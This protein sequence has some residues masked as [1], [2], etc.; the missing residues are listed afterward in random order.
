MK[1]LNRRL[2]T[3]LGALLLSLSSAATYAGPLSLWAADGW[4]LMSD[5]AQDGI[6]GPGGGGQQFD[7]EGLYFKQSG[8]LLSIGLQSGFNLITGYESH[9]AS[10]GDY[11]AGDLA[12]SFDGS[13]GPTGFE[14]GLDFGL[15]T[16]DYQ[17]DLVDMGSTTGIDPAGFYS[18]SSWNNDVYSGH[19]SSNPFAIDGG[20]LL[21]SFSSNAS[22]SGVVGG[23]TSYYRT[24]TFDIGSLGL[25][26]IT[27]LDAHWT[28]SC[29]NDVIN[30]S[31]TLTSVPE[32]S[33]L[34]LMLGGLMGMGWIG[35]RK[36][37]ATA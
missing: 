7:A 4:T 31:G 12:L 26:G 19:T 14:Y 34:A 20:A 27:D 17:L 37:R 30:G 6:I 21:S 11:Y 25:S 35:R 33:M 24:V 23:E 3:G 10:P 29:G 5:P 8:S 18:V 2:I 15:L 13:A 9:A 22:G 16:K 36:K 1:L 28:M 32:P